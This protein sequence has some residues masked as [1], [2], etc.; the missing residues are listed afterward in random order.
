VLLD[1]PTSHID[2]EMEILLTEA[3]QRLCRGRTVLTIAHRLSTIIA[4]DQI[5]V[6]DNGWIVESGT[7]AQLADGGGPYQAL[8]SAYRGKTI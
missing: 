2:P 3:T 5:I 6:M 1:E 7:H 8:A 4:S